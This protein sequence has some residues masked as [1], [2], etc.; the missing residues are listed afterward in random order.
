MRLFASIQA[1]LRCSLWRHRTTQL[2]TSCMQ[3]PIIAPARSALAPTRN[4]VVLFRQSQG[5]GL[6]RRASGAFPY[7]P[8]LRRI[9]DSFMIAS[10]RKWV[11][12]HAHLCGPPLKRRAPSALPA[13]PRFRMNEFLRLD[14]LICIRAHCQALPR[15]NWRGRSRMQPRCGEFRASAAMIGAAFMQRTS[16]STHPDHEGRMHPNTAAPDPASRT[17]THP[18]CTESTF[19]GTRRL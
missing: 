7:E 5:T 15:G 4:H 17:R 2:R 14:I 3:T 16:P 6:K 10:M 13:Y 1:A 8:L 9:G 11:R 19:A 18:L 12:R